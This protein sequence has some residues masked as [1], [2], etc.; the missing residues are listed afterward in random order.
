MSSKVNLSTS[1][2]GRGAQS[3]SGGFFE[4]H[5]AWAPGV[6]L[7][8]TLNFRAKALIISTVFLLPTA[9]L[10]WNFLKEFLAKKQDYLNRGGVF[11]VPIPSP[12]VIDLTG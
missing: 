4:H 12:V 2:A 11:I 7:F 8:R 5:G 10:A 6:R 3:S 1:A 9:L